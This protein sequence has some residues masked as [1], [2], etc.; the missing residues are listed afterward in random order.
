MELM[1]TNLLAPKPHIRNS[2]AILHFVT[3]ILDLSVCRVI[4]TLTGWMR[5]QRACHVSNVSYMC[6]KALHPLLPV[7][8]HAYSTHLRFLD[9]YLLCAGTGAP[10]GR[11]ARARPKNLPGPAH[12]AQA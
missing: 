9:P 10:Q 11:Q 4:I 12:Q 2:N 3:H 5:N 1:E 8:A 6:T 7:F